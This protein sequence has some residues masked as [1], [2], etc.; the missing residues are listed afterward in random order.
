MSI[1]KSAVSKSIS[2]IFPPPFKPRGSRYPNTTLKRAGFGVWCRLRSRQINY[3]GEVIFA[4]KN[5][6]VRFPRERWR[7]AI[8]HSLH[9]DVAA[10]S[11]VCPQREEREKGWEILSI[12][13]SAAGPTLIGRRSPTYKEPYSHSGTLFYIQFQRVKLITRRSAILAIRFDN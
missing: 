9:V 2:K 5:C 13:F 12:R 6:S 8:R 7:V 1:A 3:R 4:G 11:G 10:W